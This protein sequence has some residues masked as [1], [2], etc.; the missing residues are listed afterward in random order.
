M[1]CNGKTEHRSLIEHDTY[2]TCSGLY[3]FT[4]VFVLILVAFHEVLY[5]MYFVLDVHALWFGSRD[6][7]MSV[8]LGNIFWLPLNLINSLLLISFFYYLLTKDP[9]YCPRIGN[10]GLSFF[11]SRYVFAKNNIHNMVEGLFPAVLYYILFV[12]TLGFAIDLYNHTIDDS[13]R[14]LVF[15][16]A[17]PTIIVCNI[18]LFIV[19]F[20]SGNSGLRGDPWTDLHQIFPNQDAKIE[21]LKRFLKESEQLTIDLFPLDSTVGDLIQI[22]IKQHIDLCGIVNPLKI[23]PSILL[24]RNYSQKQTHYGEGGVICDRDKILIQGVRSCVVLICTSTDQ[25]S[26]LEMEGGPQYIYLRTR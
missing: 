25:Q 20:C 3:K 19:Y 4:T 9:S 16:F 21:Q 17:D 8:A 10:A 22:A 24:I 6:R 23:N 12:D 7:E 15:T 18:V 13:L 1:C 11:G 14:A 26:L 2:A 5:L